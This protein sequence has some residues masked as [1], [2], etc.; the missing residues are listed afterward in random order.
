MRSIHRL[1]SQRQQEIL[2]SVRNIIALR[3]FE[4]LTVRGIARDIHV[5]EG[6]LYRHFKSKH[7]IISCLIDELELTLIDTVEASAQGQADPLAKLESIFMKHVSFVEKRKAASFVLINETLN[8]KD[9]FLQRKMLKILHRYLKVINRIL[10]EGV[11]EG[12]FRKDI[13]IMPASI[14][15]FG[16]VHSLATLWALSGFKYSQSMKARLKDLFEVYK[17]GILK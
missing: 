4:N 1:K 11:S 16:M 9:K 17:R 8:L 3:G 5:T 7:E 6:A 13:N 15:F 10:S 12:V 2:E 14:V